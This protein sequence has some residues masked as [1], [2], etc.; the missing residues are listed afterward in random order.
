[1]TGYVDLMNRYLS[2]HQNLNKLLDE[3]IAEYKNGIHINKMMSMIDNIM[4]EFRVHFT[5][6][7]ML[8]IQYKEKTNI[9]ITIERLRHKHKM[10]IQ[11]L[12]DETAKI[13]ERKAN[14]ENIKKFVLVHEHLEVYDLYPELARAISDEEQE[15]IMQDILANEEVKS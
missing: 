13:G 14:F 8:Y 6:E 3:L 11:K 5:E 7:E 2:S 10:I 9:M 1:M 12:S 15:S 4:H